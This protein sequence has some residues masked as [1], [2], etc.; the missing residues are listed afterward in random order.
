MAVLQDQ[1]VRCLQCDPRPGPVLPVHGLHRNRP[2][3]RRSGLDKAGS[4]LPGGSCWWV[5]FSCSIL[6]VF[7]LISPPTAHCW[8]CVDRHVSVLWRAIGPTLRPV[9]GFPLSGRSALQTDQRLVPD[10][11]TAG[12]HPKMQ[13]P[14]A[15]RGGAAANSEHSQCR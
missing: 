12:S 11:C 6:L 14:A 1:C 4:G 13:F 7:D 10:V 15:T 2:N 8:A 9:R 5:W 3:Q